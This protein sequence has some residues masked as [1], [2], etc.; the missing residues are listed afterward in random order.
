MKKLIEFGY[1]VVSTFQSNGE[2]FFCSEIESCFVYARDKYLRDYTETKEFLELA[3][4]Y[5]IDPKFIRRMLWEHFSEDRNLKIV[6]IECRE[7]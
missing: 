6:R 2:R 4:K 1:R 5:S 3:A 7:L